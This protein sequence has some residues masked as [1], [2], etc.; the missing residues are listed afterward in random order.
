MKNST[1]GLE[2]MLVACCNGTLAPP[3]MGNVCRVIGTGA[4][5]MATWAQS[6]ISR[7]KAARAARRSGAF[8]GVVFMGRTRAGKTQGTGA[9]VRG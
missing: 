5:G 4:M 6:A 8:I 7:A 9:H 1:N 2:A 3:T